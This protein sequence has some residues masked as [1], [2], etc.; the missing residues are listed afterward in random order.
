MALNSQSSCLLPVVS[1]TAVCYHT[2]RN[3]WSLF[4]EEQVVVLCT[5]LWSL[6]TLSWVSEED[7]W[8]PSDHTQKPYASLRQLSSAILPLL[9]GIILSP[10]PPYGWAFNHLNLSSNT[11][12]SQRTFLFCSKINF[13][14][15]CVPNLSWIL[16]LPLELPSL[17]V[18]HNHSK[19]AF[20]WTAFSVT[21][22]FLH[23]SISFSFSFPWRG[24]R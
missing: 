15:T 21:L 24:F 23:L 16:H 2:W 17:I 20:T 10:R 11:T 13:S 3:F 9:A 14:F 1:I 5:G 19:S 4:I 12:L 6:G 18:H 22:L 8:S 7:D